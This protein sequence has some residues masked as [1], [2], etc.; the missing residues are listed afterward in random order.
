MVVQSKILFINNTHTQ[1]FYCDVSR[2]VLK[3]INKNEFRQLESPT[4]KFQGNL[5]KYKGGTRKQ[6]LELVHKIPLGDFEG[7]SGFSYMTDVLTGIKTAI[8]GMAFLGKL[9]KTISTDYVIQDFLLSVSSLFMKLNS[10]ISGHFNI[11][12]LIDACLEIYR[13]AVAGKRCKV[14][15]EAEMLVPAAVAS[16]SMF[17]PKDLFEVI[18]RMQTLSSGKIFD[19]IG[20]FY[21]LYSLL[22]EFLTKVQFYLPFTVPPFV[23][24]LL[25]NIVDIEQF[26]IVYEARKLIKSHRETPRVLMYE[27]FSALVEKLHTDITNNVGVPEWRK[28]SP[29]INAILMDFDKLYKAKQAFKS[30]S[31]IEPACFIFQGPPNCMKSVYMTSLI[32]FYNNAGKSSYS[33]ITRAMND[34]KDFWDSYNSEDIYYSDDVGQ[35]SI[36]QWR[37][38]IN[39]IAPVKMPLECASVELKDTKYFTSKLMLMTTNQFDSLNG[40]TSNS[41]ITEIT[42]L[43]RRCYV[44]DFKNVKR[45]EAGLEGK[46]AFKYFSTSEKRWIRSF[47]PDLIKFNKVF[48][49]LPTSW[50]AS[51]FQK[52]LGW[53][54]VITS[55][56]TQ[57]KDSFFINNQFTIDDLARIQNFSDEL[58][59]EYNVS[60]EDAVEGIDSMEAQTG[61]FNYRETTE[62]IASGIQ[63]VH[64]YAAFAFDIISDFV[65]YAYERLLDTMDP[66]NW[67]EWVMYVCIG[68]F[69]GTI[70]VALDYYTSYLFKIKKEKDDAKAKPFNGQAAE[71]LHNLHP[72]IRSIAKNVYEIDLYASEMEVYSQG[73]G[74]V[75]GRRILTVGHSSLEDQGFIKIYANRL[76]NYVLVDMLPVK[77]VYHDKESDVRVWE[78]PKNFPTPF[79]DLAHVFKGDV[80]AANYFINPSGVSNIS[81]LMARPV[82]ITT[83]YTITV[84]DSLYT[85]YLQNR[86]VF[87]YIQGKGTCGS[88]ISDESG[89]VLGIHVAGS[90]TTGVGAAIRWPDVI[91]RDLYNAFSKK[92]DGFSFEAEISER[93]LTDFSG[94]KLDTGISVHTPKNSDIIKS[95]L[96]GVFPITR[97][98]A[99]LKVNG[100]HTIKDVGKKSFVPVKFVPQSEVDFGKSIIRC[101]L[102]DFDDLPMKEVISG[103]TLLSGINKKSSN[104][105]GYLQGKDKYVDFDKGELTPLGQYA[106]DKFLTKTQDMTFE[107]QDVLWVETLKDELR[108]VDKVLPRSF[109]VSS[110]MNQILTK[111]VFGNMVAH[112]IQNKWFNGISVGIN[113][114]SEWQK[115]FDEINPHL[116]WAGDIKAWD[117]SMLPQVQHA[118]LDVMEEYYK[119]DKRLFRLACSVIPHS[120]VVMN[121][122]VYLTSHSMPSGSFLTA[123]FN[124]L[125]NRFY[126]AM[127]YYRECI[128]NGVKPTR[129]S[130]LKDIKDF[131]YGDDKLNALTDANKKYFLNALTMKD[132]FQ[133]LGMDL[134]DASKGEIVKPFQEWKDITFLKRSFEYKNPIGMVCPL[135]NQTLFSTMSWYKKGETQEQTLKEKINM[136]QREAYLHREGSEWVNQLEQFCSINGVPFTR[137]PESYLKE[138]YLSGEAH[139]YLDAQ[140]GIKL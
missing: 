96:Y 19:D 23:S 88:V 78:L 123:I 61:W 90:T 91:R 124:S 36:T 35:Q 51:E 65:K 118:I 5:I 92:G 52:A 79:K 100:N 81:T 129:V 37:N 102:D 107:V 86:D 82:T 27:D 41:G 30:S 53:M 11:S 59:N 105:Y 34:G 8:E 64:E 128:R 75:S 21:T 83:P 7:Q 62:R 99:N 58:L 3:S 73:V 77:T 39:L 120:L 63:S 103:N 133:S 112:I 33:H 1:Y 44:F 140:Y 28:K 72:S 125:V 132:F 67:P 106:Y 139:L 110:L 46:I 42:A 69:I 111:Q 130:F 121:D 95:P 135:D 48:G 38:L 138:L 127:W 45:G 60:F 85:G 93:I 137:V 4:I 17:L 6:A 136:F 31:R 2:L 66:S 12:F 113:V 119:G 24:D 98:P 131:V 74:F 116:K 20:G 84:R 15:W 68:F 47:P 117:G 14:A 13:L 126:T 70:G 94:I 57:M 22:V 97:V 89:K 80:S 9:K 71:S 26:R 76:E 122:D 109:R 115:L 43:W 29:G 55:Q 104:G 50:E 49:S 54:H 56:V 87:Y 25:R 18:R 114:Y 101:F 134:T 108:S 16:L 40:L 32:N 10:F